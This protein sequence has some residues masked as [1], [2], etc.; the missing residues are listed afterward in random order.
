MR[1]PTKKKARF[2][3]DRAKISEAE[4]CILTRSRN[5]IKQFFHTMGKTNTQNLPAIEMAAQLLL[6][7]LHDDPSATE[8]RPGLGVANF[9]EIP[10]SCLY[11]KKKK[12]NQLF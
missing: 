8:S 10:I 9:R 5:Q 1:A 2:S 7:R 3:F 6:G 11:T 12:K 4:R